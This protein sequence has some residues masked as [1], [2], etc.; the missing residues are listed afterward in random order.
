MAVWKKHTITSVS[1]FVALV[2]YR[3]KEEERGGNSSDFLFRGQPIDEPLRP[4]LAREKT[5]GRFLDVE[6]LIL[7]EFERVSFPLTE[8]QPS[9]KWDLIALAQHH[10]LPTRLLDWTYSALAALWFAVKKPPLVLD[11]KTLRHGVV[12]ILKPVKDDFIKS[13]SDESPF[14][15]RRTRIFRPKVI[16]RRIAAQAGVFTV[17]KVFDEGRSVSLEKNSLF[18]KKLEKVIVPPDSFRSL[19]KE[20]NAC[21]VNYLSMFPDLDGLGQHLAWRYTWYKDELSIQ[22][23]K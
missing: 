3:K 12:W 2:E 20:L 18:A 8:F 10:G 13:T 7:E 23:R 19:R 21:G 14:E 1:D 17:H 11:D 22:T 4:K 5:R 6:R 16:A 9:S 15:G